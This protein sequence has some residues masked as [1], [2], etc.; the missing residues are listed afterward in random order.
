MV[1]FSGRQVVEDLKRNRALNILI[2]QKSH[3]VLFFFEKKILI[4][5]HKKLN[6][7]KMK[8]MP[9][10]IDPRDTFLNAAVNVMTTFI[11]N[12]R[13]DFGDPQQIKIMSWIEVKEMKQ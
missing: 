2:T 9:G 13:L 6:E 11:L 12:E 1:D 5:L 4:N 8:T 7:R 3:E 10:G